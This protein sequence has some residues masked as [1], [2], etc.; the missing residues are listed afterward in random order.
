MPK[1]L[2]TGCSSGFGLE[3]ARYFLEHGWSVIATMRTPKEDLLP[4]SEHLQVLGLD[5]TDEAS[6]RQATAA[7]GEID[8]LVNNAG[9]GL[10]SA[11]EGTPVEAIRNLFEA[12]VIGMMA[13][14]KSF[15]PQFRQRKTGVIVNVSSSVTYQPLPMLTVYRA[16][17][18]AVNAFSESLALELQPFGVRVRLV[19]P[20][21]SP[22]TAF[23]QNFRAAVEQNGVVVPEPYADLAKNMSAHVAST[24]GSKTKP[25]DVAEAVWQAVTD[26]SCPTQLP[27]GQ[28]AVEK[29]ARIRG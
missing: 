25:L 20:G 22:G 23:L 27:A 4:G 17:K 16:T 6:I 2:I 10:M 3:T 26:P 15:L 8:A 13:V 21:H 28:D 7:A 29:E 12:N 18:A 19:I 14:T 1:I 24:S 5:V 11:L 9:V